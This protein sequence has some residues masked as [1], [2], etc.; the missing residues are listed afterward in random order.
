MLVWKKYKDSEKENAL[1]FD[2][3]WAVII[4]TDE[5]SDAAVAKF[6]SLLAPHTEKVSSLCAQAYGQV[7]TKKVAATYK[8]LEKI[9]DLLCKKAGIKDS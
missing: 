8:S 7:Y 5:T 4:F 9:K 3:V 1:Y 2:E 6:K